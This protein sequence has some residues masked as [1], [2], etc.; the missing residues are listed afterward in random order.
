MKTPMKRFLCLMAAWAILCPLFAQDFTQEQEFVGQSCTSIMVGRK[1]S[2]DGSV[3]T[4]HTCDGSYRT[5]VQMEPA[6]DHQPGEMHPVLRGTMK[7]KFRGD[8]TGVKLMG[9]IPQV[10]HTYAYL[11][12]AY[13][14]LNEKQL[15]I[16]ETTFGGPDTLVNAAGWFT[17]EELERVPATPSG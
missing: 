17:I 10:A 12:T 5:W 14:C 3:I 11:N 9:E 7:T 2:T 15:A 8:T 16:G 1:A 13:P 4:S 6:A